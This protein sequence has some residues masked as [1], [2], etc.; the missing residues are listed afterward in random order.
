MTAF[1]RVKKSRSAA[2][3]FNIIRTEG[4]KGMRRTMLLANRLWKARV[5]N[6]SSPFTFPGKITYEKGIM[7]GTVRAKS[8]K[9]GLNRLNWTD[10][11]TRPHVIEARRKPV[12]RF[13]LGHT[14]KTAPDGR[15]GGSGKATGSWISTKK[16]KH[17]GTKK[18]DMRGK[19][20]KQVDPIHSRN[21]ARA[22]SVGFRRTHK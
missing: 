11:G 8:S 20:K 5:A 1:T 6:W 14:P 16:V 12:L 21:M 2:E 17:P 18:R 10:R 4:E 13:R 3:R 19:I 9:R 7:V 22:L 15:F